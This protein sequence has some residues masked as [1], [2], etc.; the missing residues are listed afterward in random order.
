LP[1]QP[2]RR[3]REHEPPVALTL[4]HFERLLAEV[5]ATVEVHGDHPPPLVG[6]E[7]VERCGV[8]D[9]GVAHH[10]VEPAE[11]VDRGVDD[12]LRRCR[13]VH[14]VVGR[15]RRPAGT[16]DLV[17]DLLRDARVGAVTAHAAAEVVDHD[18]R[19]PARQFGRVQAA[20][21]PSGSGDDDDLS[22]ELDHAATPPRRSDP[23]V[24]KD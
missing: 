14:R 11:A 15:H 22:L 7:L 18:R 10:G 9:A 17:G 21:T 12:R 19:A 3:D 23:S 24:N 6:G 13:R 1:E 2:R 20:E 8:K 4:H 16:G 5:E